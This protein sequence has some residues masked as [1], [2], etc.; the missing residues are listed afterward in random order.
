[1]LGSNCDAA[2]APCAMVDGWSCVAATYEIQCEFSGLDEKV[3]QIFGE[4]AVR[5]G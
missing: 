4:A 2:I 5:G 3:P 1:M